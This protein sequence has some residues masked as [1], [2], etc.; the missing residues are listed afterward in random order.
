M[1][2]LVLP[3]ASKAGATN[4]SK[5]TRREEGDSGDVRLCKELQAIC[6]GQ[7][8]VKESSLSR[9]VLLNFLKKKEY[10]KEVQLVQVQVQEMGGRSFGV[11][12]DNTANTVRALKSAI[13]GQEG[14]QMWTQ[15]LFAFGGKSEA[16][17]EDSVMVSDGSHFALCVDDQGALC[18]YLFSVM[19]LA[20]LN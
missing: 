17:L 4:M 2:I 6:G 9:A 20:L 11:T 1:A 3:P 18:S 19:L 16:P 7:R 10:I 8:Y 14:F 15:N 13:E 5:R 12:T